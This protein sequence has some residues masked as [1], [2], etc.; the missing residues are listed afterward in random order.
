[1]KSQRVAHL[2]GDHA[3][4]AKL[5][6]VTGEGLRKMVRD[7]GCPG[8][9]AGVYD[10]PAVVAWRVVDAASGRNEL[11]SARERL[12]QA[13]AAARERENRLADRDVVSIRVITA[14]LCDLVLMMRNAL[15]SL[16]AVLSPELAGTA[17]PAVIR[18]ILDLHIRRAMEAIAAFDP[19][20]FA[21]IKRLR[22][23]RN[24]HE[25]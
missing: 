15:L 6:G 2:N 13:Q 4:T 9:K 7:R 21:S 1:M 10:W 17:D 18:S 8:P 19:R 3:T 20:E 24:G 12:V 14:A 25:A 5:L 22:R 16:P 11:T 23:H